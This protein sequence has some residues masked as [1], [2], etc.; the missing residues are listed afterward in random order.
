MGRMGDAKAVPAREWAARAWPADSSGRGQHD[1]LIAQF[2][3]D[4]RPDLVDVTVAVHAM[5]HACRAV[6]L[7]DW[8][9]LAQ[10]DTH[11]MLHNITGIIGAPNKRA[12][13]V[14]ELQTRADLISLHVEDGVATVTD[15]PTSQPVYQ[16]LE[17]DVQEEDAVNAPAVRRQISIERPRLCPGAR[18]SVE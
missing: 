16:R 12:A 7:N 18:E 15:A 8:H 1:V 3:Q 17:W 10:V 4:V 11:A 5:E 2:G 6:V 14:W 9:R 13:A